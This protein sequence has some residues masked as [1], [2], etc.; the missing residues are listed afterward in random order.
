[1]LAPELVPALFGGQWAPIIPVLQILAVGGLVLSVS[2]FNTTLLVGLGKPGWV[3]GLTLVGTMAMIV[4]FILVAQRGIVAIA[5]VLVSIKYGLAPLYTWM[6]HRAISLDLRAYF[7]Q[8]AAPLAGS[9]AMVATV[10]GLRYVLGGWPGLHGSLIIYGL[11]GAVVYLAVVQFMSPSLLRR[12]LD[13]ARL[14]RRGQQLE[15]V[16]PASD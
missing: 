11:A 16:S 9:L 6:I 8:Y 4:G 2:R 10:L 7:G 12:L 15:K 3:L 13:L 5:A 1:V 14:T